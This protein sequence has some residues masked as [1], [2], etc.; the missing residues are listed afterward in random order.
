M[1]LRIV[2][3]PTFFVATIPMR[4]GAEGDGPAAISKT[5]CLLVARSP[6]CCT[7]RNSARF[8]IRRSFPNK[9]RVAATAFA[10][11]APGELP[12]ARFYF[13]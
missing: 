13:L 7:R 11:A 1:R 10:E 4:E 9:K 3:S 5:K 6:V 2:A 8:R 12:T